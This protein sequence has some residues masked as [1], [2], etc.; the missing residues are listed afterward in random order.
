M[1]EPVDSPDS[2]PSA[3]LNVT[4]GVILIAVIAMLAWYV[5]S[6]PKVAD[7]TEDSFKNVVT[8]ID[9]QRLER[10]R[11]EKYGNPDISPAQEEVEILREEAVKSNLMQFENKGA[12][13]VHDARVAT[14]YAANEVITKIDMAGFMAAGRP[15]FDGCSKGFDKLL[16]ALKSGKITP[17]QARRDPGADFADYRKYCG[18][19]YP[20]LES[21]GLVQGGEWVNPAVGPH[22]FDILNRLRWAGVL[23]MRRRPSEQITPYELELFTR[24]RSGSEKLP[25]DRRIKLVER[26]AS[27]SDALPKHE[28]VGNIYFESGQVD[29]ALE[30]YEKA[31]SEHRDDPH[32]QAKCAWLARKVGE[33]GG[34]S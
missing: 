20:A 34:G 5:G 18:K 24:W 14:N 26:S 15:V 23:D 27:A 13:A 33:Q 22:L 28:I 9:V 7:V 30:E 32:L 12:R 8:E 4:I 1:S 29:K 21:H 11:K 19:A 10:E 25:A 2:N 3:F 16:G 17:E 6:A 31:C